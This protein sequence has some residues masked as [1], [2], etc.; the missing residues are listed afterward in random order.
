MTDAQKLAVFVAVSVGVVLLPWVIAEIRKIKH[1][2]PI[3]VFG[4]AA[5]CITVAIIRNPNGD[6]DVL[7]VPSALCWL[8]VLLWAALDR[9]AAAP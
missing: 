1:A 8:C 9:P 7:L 6:A 5:G 3:K 4:I 2:T